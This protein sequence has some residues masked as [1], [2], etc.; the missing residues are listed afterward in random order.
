MSLWASGN[1]EWAVKKLFGKVVGGRTGHEPR[2][3]APGTCLTVFS[4]FT[5]QTQ[6]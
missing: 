2:L 3:Q 6:I 1:R 4:D 5:Y